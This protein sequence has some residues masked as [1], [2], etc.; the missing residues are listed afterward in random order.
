[1]NYQIWLKQNN[2]IDNIPSRLQY[3]LNTNVLLLQLDVIKSNLQNIPKICS[4]IFC[5]KVALIGPCEICLT[6]SHYTYFCSIK[7]FDQDYKN[8]KLLY[9]SNMK[10][11]N[12]PKQTK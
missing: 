2:L 1:M 8:H 5:N 9:H 12:L 3:K 11:I 6:F 7:C 10:I 4:T